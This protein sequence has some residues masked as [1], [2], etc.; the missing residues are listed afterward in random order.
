MKFT[1]I[2]VAAMAATFA[3]ANPVAIPEDAAPTVAAAAAPADSGVAQAGEAAINCKLC[4]EHFRR[5]MK[6]MACWVSFSTV[7]RR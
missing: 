7:Q 5:C 6:S 4:D 3:T 2:L 1:T